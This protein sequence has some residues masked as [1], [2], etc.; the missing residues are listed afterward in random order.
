MAIDRWAKE[1]LGA[2][3]IEDGI[4]RLVNDLFD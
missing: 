1:S 4:T 2:H 3:R